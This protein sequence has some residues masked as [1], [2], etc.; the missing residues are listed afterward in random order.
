MAKMKVPKFVLFFC[1]LILNTT[2]EWTATDSLREYMRHQDP[3]TQ[4]GTTTQSLR[5]R[6]LDINDELRE[7]LKSPRVSTV[8]AAM[9][10]VLNHHEGDYDEELFKRVQRW[11]E[12]L[13]K[14][15]GLLRHC[16][17]IKGQGWDGECLAVDR[18]WNSVRYKNQMDNPWKS[19]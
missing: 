16:K 2:A 19:N 10:H 5:G 14:R 12:E 7:A 15:M 9:E 6:G 1:L 17:A 3:G 13:D 8:Q 18:W 11:Y 4:H